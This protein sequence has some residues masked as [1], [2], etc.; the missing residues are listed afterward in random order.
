MDKADA[1]FLEMML[2][3]HQEIQIAAPAAVVFESVLEQL[4]TESDWPNGQKLNLK[5]EPWPGGRWY[6]DLGN[7]SGHFWGHV[8]VIKPPTL[9]EITGPFVMS[10]PAINHIQYR[11]TPEGSGTKL[12]VTH[13]AM[14][15]IL[16][17]HRTGVVT[18]W[19][20][21]LGNIKKRSER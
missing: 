1:A 2:K 18:G 14:G 3:V 11:L 7:N 20:F 21:V 9:I 12:A 8:Q 17:D 13:R 10:Y 15:D 5:F 19:E 6:R 4:G 16:P